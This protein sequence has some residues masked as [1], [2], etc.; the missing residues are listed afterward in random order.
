MVERTAFPDRIQRAELWLSRDASCPPR[1]GSLFLWPLHCDPP[2]GVVRS[3]AR[4]EGARLVLALKSSSLP[5]TDK[6]IHLLLS[7]RGYQLTG[8]RG[9]QHLVTEKRNKEWCPGEEEKRPG[10]TAVCDS[11]ETPCWRWEN[12]IWRSRK[13]PPR[14]SLPGLVFRMPGFIP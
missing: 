8:Y 5:I 1:L 12:P 11:Q 4:W 7:V 13:W 2:W 14:V 10:R 3:R 6:P 9:A